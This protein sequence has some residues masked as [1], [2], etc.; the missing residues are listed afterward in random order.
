MIELLRFSPS[1]FKV[2]GMKKVEYVAKDQILLLVTY[3]CWLV[4]IHT[5]NVKTAEP[6][7]AIYFVELTMIPVNKTAEQIGAIYFVELTMIP[8][9]KTAEQ[10][11]LYI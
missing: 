3:V 7:G 1:G 6:I 2:K 4:C 8:G 5:K 9:N 11:G 10:I